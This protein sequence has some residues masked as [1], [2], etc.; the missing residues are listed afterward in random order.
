MLKVKDSKAITLIAL[1]ITIVVMLI[2]ATITINLVLG[3]NGIVKKAKDAALMHKK[4][5]YFQD[6]ELEIA[7]EQLERLIENKEEPF[8]VSLQKR[9]QGTEVASQETVK[10]Y[11]KKPWVDKAEINLRTVLVVFTTDKYQLLIDVD[12]TNNTAKVRENSFT[13]KGKDSTVTF[14][15]NSAEGNMDSITITQGL[16]IELP[17]NEFTKTNYTFVGWYEDEEGNGQRYNPG[18]AYIVNEDKTLYAKWSQHAIT[19]TYNPGYETETTMSNTT[20][21]I[22]EKDNLL[23]NTFERQGYTFAGWKDQ[24]NQDYTNEQEITASKDLEL[25]AQWTLTEYSITYNLDGGTVSTANPTTYTIETSSFT[26]N[27]PTKNGYTFAGWTGSNGTTAQ[28]SITIATGSTGNKSYTAN[29]TAIDYTI[30]YNLDGGTNSS[31]NPGTY[32]IT[33]ETITLQDP[34]KEGFTFIGWTTETVTTPTKNLQIVKGSTGGKSFTANWESASVEPLVLYDS[35]NVMQNTTGGWSNQS[36][37]SNYVAR[38]GTNR[39]EFTCSNSWGVISYCQLSTNNLVDISKYNKI[40]VTLSWAMTKSQ[41]WHYFIFEVMRNTSVIG[42]V[43]NYYDKDGK[44]TTKSVGSTTYTYNLGNN[45]SN[46]IK[47]RL[48]G[49]NNTEGYVYVTKVWLEK[50][51]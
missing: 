29:W 17:E 27:N 20:I 41:S 31:S 5:E 28:T 3:D 16:G 26:L 47:L 48:R 22:G 38:L 8:I 21:E 6:I 10:V 37:N 40:N 43:I 30:T 36:D 51:Q 44:E 12:N 34:A 7:N 4:S 11:T 2:L 39:M 49:A 50:V 23:A 35:G 15:G 42:T 25:T 33:T 24:D 9:L 45:N 14:N 46:S 19:I 13:K 1:V 32:K 18:E